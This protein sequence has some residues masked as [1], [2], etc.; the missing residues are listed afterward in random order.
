MRYVAGHNGRRRN[1]GRTY[2]PQGP[3][4][5]GFCQCGCGERTPLAK[6][7]CGRLGLVKGKPLRHC[8]G[9]GGRVS[10]AAGTH[11][12]ID[13]DTGCW[14]WLKKRDRQGY[15][16][17]RRKDRM[18]G[19]HRWVYEQMR[20]PIPT[21]LDLDHLCGNPACVNPAHLEPVTR[22]E[23]LRRGRERRTAA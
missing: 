3:N 23:N 9:H 18:L 21:G 16:V 13:P 4:P 5:T 10:V 7:H 14:L 6:E 19:A 15:G 1:L 2:D 8:P 20:E 11:W 17:I 22:A 12:R